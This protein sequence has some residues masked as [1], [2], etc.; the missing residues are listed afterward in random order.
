MPAPAVFVVKNGSNASA[1]TASGM[2][3]PVSVTLSGTNRSI[4]GSADLSRTFLGGFADPGGCESSARL[5]V[6]IVTEPAYCMASLAFIAL[7]SLGKVRDAS[8][9]ASPRWGAPDLLL[10]VLA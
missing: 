8:G 7:S 9:S 1:S 4:A 5:V 6:R 10:P 2:P 3:L